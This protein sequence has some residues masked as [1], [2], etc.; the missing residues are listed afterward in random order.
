[1]NPAEEIKA[2]EKQPMLELIEMAV[3][4]MYSA[5]SFENNEA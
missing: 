5:T 4:L 1:M 2:V 3:F